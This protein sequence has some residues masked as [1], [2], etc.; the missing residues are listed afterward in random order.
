MRDSGTSV[1]MNR[2]ALCVDLLQL[3]TVNI[4]IDLMWSMFRRARRILLLF[5]RSV[6]FYCV[7]TCLGSMFTLSHVSSDG[8]GFY[9][10]GIENIEQNEKL[11]AATIC[12]SQ[13]RCAQSSDGV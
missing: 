11:P 13:R 1:A 10:G 7:T 4:S 3:R 6:S 9:T 5:S 8:R 2:R 12:V